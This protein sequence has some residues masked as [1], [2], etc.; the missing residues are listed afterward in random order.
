MLEF[1]WLTSEE[2]RTATVE[3]GS[4]SEVLALAQKLQAEGETR[5]SDDQ[6]VEMGRELGVQPQYI[7]EALRLR[8]RSG[9]PT[10]ALQT[11]PTLPPTDHNPIASVA[12]VLLLV[13]ALGLLPRSLEALARSHVAP[14]LF[15]CFAVLSSSLAGWSAR[16]SRLAGVAGALA[17][18]VLLL[19]AAFYPFYD[20]G[21][22]ADAV[23]FSLISLCPLGSALGRVAARA[24]RWAERFVDRPRLSTA[25]R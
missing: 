11:E 9:Q 8:R 25:G 1:R 19:V 22:G 24:R 10:R 12:Q 16:Y 4:L 21:L 20:P 15:L 17:V 23:F 5:V 3:N 2:R 18:P 7:R 6:V 13:F 14:G